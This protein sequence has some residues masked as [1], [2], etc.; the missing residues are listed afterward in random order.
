M[1]INTR[2]LFQQSGSLA[3]LAGAIT[4]CFGIL[5]VGFEI[6]EHFKVIEQQAIENTF[7][8]YER[9]FKEENLKRSIEKTR[10]LQ[11]KLD[12]KCPIIEE[13]PE[14]PEEL[15]KKETNEEEDFK[16]KFTEHFLSVEDFYSGLIKCIDD[17][18][19]HHNTIETLFKNDIREFVSTFQPLICTMRK[20]W[21]RPDFGQKLT[22]FSKN[23]ELCKAKVVDRPHATAW[24]LWVVA[25][26]L[27]AAKAIFLNLLR[28][29]F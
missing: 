6:H 20:E 14:S 26:G 17:K 22:K 4:F 1:D 10:S 24:G 7:K 8:F 16:E 21:N 3:S 11:K 2:K 12:G 28:L 15:I 13:C 25:S 9:Q 27:V 19:C 29:Q 5:P 18:N 23:K